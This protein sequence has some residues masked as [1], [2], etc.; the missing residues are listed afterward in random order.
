[1]SPRALRPKRSLINSDFEGYKLN[2]DGLKATSKPLL[3]KVYQVKRDPNKFTFNY[4]KRQLMHNHLFFNQWSNDIFFVDENLNIVLIQA[5]KAEFQYYTVAKLESHGE[6]LNSFSPTISFPTE[7]LCITSSGCGILHLMKIHKDGQSKQFRPLATGLIHDFNTPISILNSHHDP[8]TNIIHVLVLSLK[9][10]EEDEKSVSYA[11]LHWLQI[12]NSPNDDVESTVRNWKTFKG[13]NLPRECWLSE[14]YTELFV[15]SE[16]EFELVNV[17]TY[18][19]LHT[20]SSQDEAEDTIKYYHWHQCKEMLTIVFDL[21]LT[22]DEVECQFLHNFLSIKLKTGKTLLEGTLEKM[23]LQD[24]SKWY[25]QEGRLE[26]VLVKKTPG[27][28]WSSVIP[29]EKHGVHDIEG[30]EL[31]RMNQ[32]HEQLEHLT[33]EGIQREEKHAKDFNIQQLEECDENL[34][35]EIKVYSINITNGKVQLETSLGG[36]MLFSTSV[37]E[38]SVPH[39]CLRYDVDGILWQ[40]SRSKT[41]FWVHIATIDA[42]GYVLAS[43][44]E[45]K[46][47]GCSPD[48]SYAV[49]TDCKSNVYVYECSQGH[50]K[51]RAQYVASFRDSDEI[52][53][54][55]VAKNKLCVLT[56]NHV[57]ILE[58]PDP[59]M[60]TNER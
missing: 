38:D 52:F 4:V 41:T 32:I 50:S 42:F 26:I 10:F 18:E 60:D 5:E 1:M 6:D 15:A 27:E 55:I 48:F 16:T 37:R 7:N 23:I 36:Q 8:T 57:H 21:T 9:D 22:Q 19:R 59:N 17:V 14:D 12:S 2:T 11:L 40:P 20:V 58:L 30:E 29:D 53:G 25:I 47:V 3:S 45:H 34:E 35:E 54:C 24:A 49:I 33:S 51:K 46:F 13:R 31:E 39:F 43:K 28:F 56:D 44:Q